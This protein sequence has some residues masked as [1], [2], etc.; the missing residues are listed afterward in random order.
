MASRQQQEEPAEPE[1]ELGGTSEADRLARLLAAGEGEREAA[2]TAM[3]TLAQENASSDHLG[4]SSTANVAAACSTPLCKV[5]C[6]PVSVV[7]AEEWR[8]AAQVFTAISCVAPARVGAASNQRDQRDHTVYSVRM[9]P[10]NVLGAMLRK[11]PSALTREDALIAAWGMAFHMAQWATPTGQDESIKLAG[12]TTPEFLDALLPTLYMA[13]IDGSGVQTPTDDRNLALLPL[14]LELVSVPEKLPDFA[15]G[16]PDH[17]RTSV[18][19]SSND[20]TYFWAGGILGA[21]GQSLQGRPAVAAHALSL[22]IIGVLMGV[23]RRVSPADLVSIKGYNSARGGHGLANWGMRELTESC[24][25]GGTDLTDELLSCGYIDLIVSSLSAAEKLGAN[26]VNGQLS[27]TILP[28]LHSIQGKALGQIEE[29]LRAIPSA[30]RF[31]VDNKIDWLGDF[32]L[33]S[34]VFGTIIAANLW[35]KS[36]ENTFGFARE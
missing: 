7:G 16:K 9:A 11:A 2:Y 23:L 5:L 28:L 12:W 26:D 3:L 19:I 14:F 4:D 32:G 36:E 18:L 21:L 35:G 27:I 33:S 13:Q 25:A 8:R 20:L 15:L 17:L 1:P 29:K 24:Q 30:L 6:K 10:D 34:G 22:D 31:L